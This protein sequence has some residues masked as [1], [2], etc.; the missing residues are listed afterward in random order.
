MT[1]KTSIHGQWSSRLVFIL[2][3]TGSA[4]GLGNIW[5]FPYIA[6]EHGGGAFVAVYLVCIAAIGVP[7]MMAEIMLGRRGRQ[8]PI[9]TMASLAKEEKANAAWSIVGWSGVLAGFFILS[10]YSV[11]A[12]WALAYVLRSASGVFNGID[13]VGVQAVFNDLVGD[14]E[15]LLAWHSLFM[16]M[17]MVVVARGV[18][19]GLE[20]AVTY[21]MPALFLLLIVMVGYAMNTGYFM[22]GLEFL[23]KPDFNRVFYQCESVAGIEQ[24][25]LSGSPILV[26]LGHAFFT[27]SLGMGA[28]MVYGSY[29]PK[30]T[31]I[32]RSAILI[33]FLDTLVA[34]VAGM[35][36]F[37]IVF[38]NGLEPG[39]GP[40]LIF[41][42]LP[43]AFGAMP[44]GQLFGTLF[45]V[46]LVFA[47]WS[48]AISLIEP[49]VAWLVENRKMSRIRAA[50]WVGLTTWIL[51][52]GSVFSFNFWSGDE[53]K[54]FGMTFFDL[55]D[56]LAANIML[57]MGGLLIAVFAGWVMTSQSSKDEFAMRGF[58]YR[59]WWVLIRFVSPL[60]VVLVFLNAVGVI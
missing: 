43:I 4:V 31:S 60:A 15:R 6:G 10:Y 37:P 48:S 59:L 7:I 5:K 28:I 18:R 38:A 32:A 36:I 19:A 17:S 41:Q 13:T 3:A 8:S 52:L 20:K 45:F 33:A 14:P 55:L 9:N 53:Y 34:L 25:E 57:P 30:Q 47:A 50:A 23:F 1:E 39:A 24:C 49:A 16:L 58:T 2:A 22:Q 42:T 21:L 11:I 12:G 27:L 51:G 29:M 44:L 35:A 40:G 56:Y 46:L 54:L 26:A